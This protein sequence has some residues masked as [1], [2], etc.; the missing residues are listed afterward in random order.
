ME[1]VVDT[2]G[3]IDLSTVRMLKSDH[4]L[5]GLAVY[6]A[7]PDMRYEPAR[8]GGRPVREIIIQPYAF[9]LSR[10]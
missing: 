6:R 1:F 5:L 2:T 9:N 8:L 3:M 7:L 4:P 10:P